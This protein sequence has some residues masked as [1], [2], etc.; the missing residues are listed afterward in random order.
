MKEHTGTIVVG[1]GVKVTGTLSVPGLASIGGTLEGEL[2]ARE[3]VV[4]QSGLM[5]GSFRSESADIRGEVNDTLVVDATLV[6]RATGRVTGTVYCGD[7]EVEKG[8]LVEGRLTRGAVPQ[9]GASQAD[10]SPAPAPP[11]PAA[12]EA[13]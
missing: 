5:T 4:G 13:P 9:A 10:A 2:V 8:G 3:L 11:A 12:P 6:V 7:I 1:E